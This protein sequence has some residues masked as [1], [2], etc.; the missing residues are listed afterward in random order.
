[1]KRVKIYAPTSG[2]IK[3]I[4]S[5]NDGVFSKGML[6]VG[7]YIIPENN[8][9]FSPFESGELKWFFNKACLLC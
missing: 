3:D 2:I 7:C 4:K 5:L 8:D 6:G 9:F 1:M